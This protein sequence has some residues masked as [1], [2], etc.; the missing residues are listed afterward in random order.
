MTFLLFE[1]KICW[2]CILLGGT[3]CANSPFVGFVGWT[4]ISVLMHQK[5]FVLNLSFLQCTISFPLYW[6]RYKKG[7]LVT[8]CMP[9]PHMQTWHHGHDITDLTSQTWHHRLDITDLA[10]Q[11]WHHRYDITDLISQTWH[12]RLD[13][14][15]MTSVLVKRVT[16]IGCGLE[17]FKGRSSP[18]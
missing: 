7:W 16:L 3:D 11:T 15:D 1:Q 12:P 17:T 18:H 10:S 14:T 2:G 8:W 9:L 5:Y 6:W 4:T 13:I